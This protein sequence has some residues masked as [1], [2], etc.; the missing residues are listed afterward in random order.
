MGAAPGCSL[1]PILRNRNTAIAVAVMLIPIA[2]TLLF[3][4]VVSSAI[5]VL[6]E[7]FFTVKKEK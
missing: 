7:L 2:L 4:Y 3:V 1:H 6:D 5:G